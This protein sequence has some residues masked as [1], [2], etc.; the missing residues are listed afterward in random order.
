VEL[1]NEELVLHQNIV[2]DQIKDERILE[3][4]LNRLERCGLDASGSCEHRNKPSYSTK[5]GEFL[6]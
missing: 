2:G 6:A 5:D 4:I 1:Y 3:W